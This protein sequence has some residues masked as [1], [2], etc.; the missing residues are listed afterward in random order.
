MDEL[1]ELLNGAFEKF[2][3]KI[4]ED[5]GLKNELAGITRSVVVDVIDEEG[6]SF[7]LDRGN[8]RDFK[9]GHLDDPDILITA[10]KEDY[11]ALFNGELKPMKAWAT[12]RLKVKASIADLMKIKKMF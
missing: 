7:Y 4:E 5:E 10:T 3:G 6:F 12:K 9:R 11:K 8:I 1:E 2:K